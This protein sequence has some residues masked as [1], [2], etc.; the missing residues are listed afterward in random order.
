MGGDLPHLPG[1]RVLLDHRGEHG[2]PPGPPGGE[3]EVSPVEGRLAPPPE[4]AETGGAETFLEVVRQEG[5]EDRVDGRVCVLE[6]AG[7]EDEQQ[8]GVRQTLGR[9]GEEEEEL[10][11]PVGEP[12]ED[13]DGDDGQHQPSD[14]SLQSLLAGGPARLSDWT[15]A[16]QLG[17]HQPVEGED[18]EGGGG[19][20]QDE[21]VEGEDGVLVEEVLQAGV[22]RPQS[23]PDDV[24]G[25]LTSLTA[26]S[27]GEEEDGQHQ[28]E[29]EQPG[30]ERHQ[31]G[32]QRRPQSVRVRFS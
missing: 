27:P 31:A 4:V 1:P 14:G 28:Q 29:G 25:G 18:E 12:A 8:G 5:V 11:S 20:A 17:H 10:Q 13:V 9:G 32:H 24:A 2:P 21:G 6:A 7:G 22:L 15:G 3:G 23:S 26:H 16:P 19:E 30:G